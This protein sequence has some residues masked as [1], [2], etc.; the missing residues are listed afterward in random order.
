MASEKAKKP[1]EATGENYAQ[2][3]EYLQRAIALDPSLLESHFNRALYRQYQ[4]LWRQAADDWRK[5]LEK[6]PNPQW[7]EEAKNYLREIEDLIKQTAT[8]RERLRK[9]FREAALRRDGEAAWQTFRNSRTSFGN[10]VLEGVID[11]Y[12]TARLTGRTENADAAL[13]IL[14]FIGDVERARTGD[15]YTYD[16]ANFYRV[17]EP[18]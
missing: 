7:A 13:Q 12:L 2:A 4:I 3:S 15:R 5:Y 16:I 14:L 8:N 11:D 9:E 18:Q 6:D 1:R 17:A 10:F